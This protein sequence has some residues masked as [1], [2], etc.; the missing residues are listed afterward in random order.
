MKADLIFMVQEERLAEDVYA[1]IAD[2]YDVSRPFTTIA[3]SEQQHQ[4][5]LAVLLDR[6]SLTDPSAGMAPGVYADA[7]LQDL[8]DQLIAQADVSLAE[9]YKVGVAIEETDIA[10]LKEALAEDGI[11]AD[12]KV[13][14]ERLTA[15][16]ENHLKAFTTK[17]TG[18]TIGTQDGTG[19]QNGRGNAGQGAGRGAGR[20]TPDRRGRGEPAGRR[21]NP[22]PCRLHAHLWPVELRQ[23]APERSARNRDDHDPSGTGRAGTGCRTRRLRDH[24]HPVHDPDRAYADPSVS[25]SAAAT[26]ATASASPA[27]TTPAA[28]ANVDTASE[29]AAWEALMSPDGEY[30][31]YAAYQGVIDSYGRV[32]PY[33][34]IRAADSNTSTPWPGS[35]SGP[36]SPCRPT[37]IWARSRRRRA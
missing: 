9:A 6:Y 18:G 1:Y 27:G 28:P 10:D 17:T 35:W 8:Y 15:G 2:T 25:T 30:A 24:A 34:T 37:P 12:V 13:V 23:P 22:E 32:E 36:A 16:S 20:G 33:V 19:L 31:A 11:P 21:A 14:Y 5:A 3:R 4:D 29:R 26:P 7:H